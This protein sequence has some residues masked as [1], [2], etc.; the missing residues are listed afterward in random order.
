MLKGGRFI[1]VVAA[2]AILLSVVSLTQ[3]SSN[4]E[5]GRPKTTGYPDVEDLPPTSQQEYRA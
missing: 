1:A 5:P 4:E 3:L 2:S